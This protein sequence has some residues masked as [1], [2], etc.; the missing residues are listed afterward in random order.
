MAN[1]VSN[2]LIFTPS[3]GTV[4]IS[5]KEASDR[6][7]EVCITDTGCGIADTGDAADL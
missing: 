3:G 5:A 1:L 4:V 7:V 2:A 6:S